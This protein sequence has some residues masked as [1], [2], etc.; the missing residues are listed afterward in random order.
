M[1]AIPVPL[2]NVNTHHAATSKTGLLLLQATEVFLDIAAAE[3][4]GS[5]QTLPTAPH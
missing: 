2:L 5:A 1:K 3:S 4:Y